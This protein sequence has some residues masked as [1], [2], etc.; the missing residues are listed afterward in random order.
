VSD[1]D[2]AQSSRIRP[3][4]LDYLMPSVMDCIPS[5]GALGLYFRHESSSSLIAGPHT[6]EPLDDL[7]DPDG[8]EAPPWWTLTPSWQRGSN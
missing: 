1:V 2:V 4:E 6:E 8:C 7:V 3:L 5:S